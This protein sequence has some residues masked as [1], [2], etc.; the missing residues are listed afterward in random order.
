MTGY[1]EG[2]YGDG[3]Y[4]GTDGAWI[5]REPAE[6]DT[7]TTFTVVSTYSPPVI[8]HVSQVRVRFNLETRRQESTFV[9]Y[10]DVE[11]T[12]ISR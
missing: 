6:H 9:L 3:G 2:L 4:G 10:S 11:G 12:V 5:S 8:Q 7:I 1:G